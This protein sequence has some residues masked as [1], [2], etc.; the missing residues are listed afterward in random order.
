MLPFRKGGEEEKGPSLRS[1]V[2]C[3]RVVF[4]GVIVF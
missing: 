4:G 2:R 3:F 1:E